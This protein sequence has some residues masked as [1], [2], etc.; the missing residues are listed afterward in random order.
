MSSPVGATQAE[1]PSASPT[2]IATT[3]LGELE[4]YA[5]RVEIDQTVGKNVLRDRLA[6]LAIRDGFEFGDRPG[7][8]ETKNHI[9]TIGVHPGRAGKI[10]EVVSWF[11]FSVAFPV[12]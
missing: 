8:T 11:R 5:R 6:K 3:K 12:I 9:I 7:C 10:F 4:D 1:A 2:S